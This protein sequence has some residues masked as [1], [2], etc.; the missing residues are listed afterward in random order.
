MY[1][2]EI[3]FLE[4]YDCEDTSLAN[5]PR[6][7]SKNVTV[8]LQ[9]RPYKTTTYCKSNGKSKHLNAFILDQW[10]CVSNLL[11]NEVVHCLPSGAEIFFLVFIKNSSVLLG[12]F[13]RLG[14]GVDSAVDDVV[15]GGIVTLGGGE[16]LV[17]VVPVV[18]VVTVGG[19]NL[20][21]VKQN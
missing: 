12:L 5:K 21:S 17:P 11:K 8:L 20:E 19:W 10:F 14:D 1:F 2:L 18:T 3:C 16:P 13:F 9:N 7:K 15:F 4:E 6:K